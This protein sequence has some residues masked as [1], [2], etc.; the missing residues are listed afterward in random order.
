MC[1]LDGKD[2]GLV[3]ED[4]ITD[5]GPATNIKEA[6]VAQSPSAAG[7]LCTAQPMQPVDAL[8]WRVFS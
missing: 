3:V 2:E 5:S 7:F 4:I 8:G 1:P 6:L